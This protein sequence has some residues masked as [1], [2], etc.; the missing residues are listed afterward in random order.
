MIIVLMANLAFGYEDLSD[1][2]RLK[3]YIKKGDNFKLDLMR[4]MS[5]YSTSINF[6]SNNASVKIPG[7]PLESQSPSFFEDEPLRPKIFKTENSHMIYVANDGHVLS[8]LRIENETK[9]TR[10]D[11]KASEFFNKNTDKFI[12]DLVLDHN[13]NMIVLYHNVKDYYK[14]DNPQEEIKYHLYAVNY[15][16]DSFLFDVEIEAPYFAKPTIKMLSRREQDQEMDPSRFVYLIFDKNRENKDNEAETPFTSHTCMKLV[17]VHRTKENNFDVEQQLFKVNDIL[18]E[19]KST[20]IKVLNIMIASKQTKQIFFFIEI[21]NDKGN[22]NKYVFRASFN[23][24]PHAKEVKFFDVKRFIDRPVEEFFMKESLYIYISKDHKMQFCDESKNYCKSGNL[25]KDWKVK[26]IMFEKQYAIVIMSIKTTNV[27]FIND[28]ERNVLTYYYD[29]FKG[30]R[31]FFLSH[32]ALNN[33]KKLYIAEFLVKGFKLRDVTLNSM[34]EIQESDLVDQQPVSLKLDDEELVNLDIMR[35]DGELVVDQFDGKSIQI[36]KTN[37]GK[38]RTQLGYA[39]KN[40]NFFDKKETHGIKYYNELDFK[41]TYEDSEVIKE[42]PYYLHQEWV[43]FN[44]MWVQNSCKSDK[45]NLTLVCKEIEHGNLN[46][47]IDVTKITRTYEIGSL[48]ILLA[49]NSSDIKIFNKRTK[50]L[51]QQQHNDRFGGG[52]ACT[53]NINYIICK[54]DNPEVK[55]QTLRVFYVNGDLLEEITEVERDMIEIMK[56]YFEET[57]KDDSLTNIQINSYGFDTVETGSLSVLFNFVF[58][59]LFDSRFFNFKFSHALNRPDMI[60]RLEFVDKNE[61]FV[62]HPAITRN[63]KM[64]VLDSQIIFSS[65]DPKFT[66]FCF[67]GNSYYKFEYLD[68]QELVDMIVLESHNLIIFIYL[69]RGDSASYFYT[70]FRITQNAVKQHIRTEAIKNYN[71]SYRLSVFSIDS[72]TIG[73]IQYNQKGN[74]EFSS[75]IYFQNGPILTSSKTEQPININGF[76]YKP[77]YIEDKLFN[78]SKFKFEK[79]KKIQIGINQENTEFYIRDYAKFI[80]NVKDITISQE[81]IGLTNLEIDTPLIAKSDDIITSLTSEDNASEIFVKETD[82]VIVHHTATATNVYSAIFKGKKDKKATVEFTLPD[83]IKCYE[84]GVSDLSLICFWTKDGLHMVSIKS[85]EGQSQEDYKIPRKVSSVRVMEENANYIAFIF[86]DEFNKFIAII[87]IDKAEKTIKAKYIGKKEMNIDDLRIIDYHHSLNIKEDRLTVIMLD[88]LSNQLLFFYSPYKTL[89][90]QYVLK[91][92]IS[93]NDLDFSIIQIDC[94]DFENTSNTFN[95]LLYSPTHI[96][97]TQI[98]RNESASRSDFKWDFTVL[99]SFYNVLYESSLD[100]YFSLWTEHTESNLFIYEQ[101]QMFNNGNKL[102][103]YDLA[104]LSAQYSQYIVELTDI[105]RVVG[106]FKEKSGEADFLKIYYV[107]GEQL[108]CKKFQIDDYKVK[109]RDLQSMDG[110]N[111]DVSVNFVNGNNYHLKFYFAKQG[112]NYVVPVQS[113]STIMIILVIGIILVSVLILCCLLAIIVL[114]KE[115][116]KNAMRANMMDD[117]QNRGSNFSFA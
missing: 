92:M 108:R 75:Y 30:V 79:D 101:D 58:K 59:A 24:S 117:S 6:S 13:S 86:K 70:I 26:W 52:S 53:V 54:Y 107:K 87:K 7:I 3:M 111:I 19:G 18:F 47:D 40:L 116:K 55:I 32:S 85:W 15:A 105:T 8:V 69:K 113:K 110:K 9:I 31:S 22:S 94:T 95:C 114:L 77:K 104:S 11:N 45:S 33:N 1:I 56:P 106:I 36:L 67:D 50:M 97:L 43:F 83:K 60:N 93:L 4:L 76:E 61:E 63:V 28:F 84:V 62:K 16:T 88:G 89:N 51:I 14:S 68:I 112:S 25:M 2:Y 72:Y 35:W 109:M 46:E 17:T 41:I 20:N 98:K 49:E 44:Q 115:R 21:P 65:F 29:N 57:K 81:S 103:M 37:D 78:I 34:L 96:F 73:I 90:Q 23:Y 39:G 38:F 27:V 42:K 102:V 74:Q 91:R 10:I 12:D 80:G 82:K 64:S 66:F 48:V 71:S 100:E 99:R 5:F